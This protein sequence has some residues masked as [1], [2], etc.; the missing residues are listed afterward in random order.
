MRW[1]PRQHSCLMGTDWN[2][3]QD[4]LWFWLVVPGG[5]GVDRSCCPFYRDG[6]GRGYP[7]FTWPFGIDTCFS[8]TGCNCRKGLWKRWLIAHSY[9]L[10]LDESCLVWYLLPVLQLKE[11]LAP[12][13]RSIQWLLR[14][15][16][17]RVWQILRLV[18]IG[19]CRGSSNFSLR[20][21]SYLCLRGLSMILL[22]Q[23]LNLEVD[24]R[25]QEFMGR[26]LITHQLYPV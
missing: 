24:S 18:T 14:S 13:D 21:K 23:L 9:S 22:D 3:S 8:V 5:R 12:M 10:A 4:A 25:F 20:S 1:P 16:F 19:K 26:F 11:P 7:S 2:R 15:G 17:V 6:Y